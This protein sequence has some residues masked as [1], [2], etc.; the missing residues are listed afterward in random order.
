MAHWFTKGTYTKNK[1]AQFKSELDVELFI[2]ETRDPDNFLN[3]GG[4]SG[5]MIMERYDKENGNGAENELYR[6][7]Y[8]A[9]LTDMPK[10]YEKIC[11]VK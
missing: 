11:S 10:A 1:L 4:Y 6:D 3:D 8:K 7:M 9:A 5:C 2:R